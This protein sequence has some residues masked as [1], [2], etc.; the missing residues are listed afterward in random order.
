MADTGFD[1]TRTVFK[2]VGGSYPGRV[3]Q[4]IAAGAP[5]FARDVVMP[6]MLHAKFLRSPYPHA[7][8]ESIDTTAAM[9]IPGVRTIAKW[10]DPDVALLGH[11]WGYG[12]DAPEGMSI[13]DQVADCEET[14]VG[15]CVCTDTEEICDQALKA[16]VINWT[17]LPFYLDPRDSCKPGSAI[18]QPAKRPQDNNFSTANYNNVAYCTPE[19]TNPANQILEYDWNFGFFS[20]HH[21]NPYT[22]VAWFAQDP[23]GASNQPDTLYIEGYYPACV[24]NMMWDMYKPL[25]ID[26]TYDKMHKL[27]LFQGGKYCDYLV[28]RCVFIAPLLAKRTG[29]PVRVANTRRDN[30]DESSGKRWSHVK[31][32]FDS[33]GLIKA[34]EDISNTDGGTRGSCGGSFPDISWSPFYTTWAGKGT[35][36]NCHLHSNSVFSYTNTTRIGLGQDWPYSWDLLTTAI[37]QVAAKVNSDPITLSLLNCHT[38]EMPPAP[39][40]PGSSLHW[41][42]DVGKPLIGWDQK[43]HQPGKGTPDADGKLHGLAFR[44]QMS[45]RHSG[46]KYSCTLDIRGDGKVYMPLRGPVRGQFIE[47]A[48]AWVVAEAL[49]AKREDVILDYDPRAAFTAVGGGSDGGT[50]SPWACKEA[51]GLLRT[52]LVNSVATSWATTADNI[53]IVDSVISKITG[54]PHSQG[55]APFAQASETKD[56]DYTVSYTGAP[57]SATWMTS[58]GRIIDT[59]NA[60]FLEVAVDP[61]TGLVDIVN[62]VTV[63]DVGKVMRLSSVKGQIEQQIVFMTGIGNG[64][65]FIYDRNTGVMLNGNDI[66]YKKPTIKDIPAINVQALESGLGNAA[67]G[68]SGISHSITAK[69]IVPCAVYNALGVWIPDAPVTPQRI[70]KALGKA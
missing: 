17:V 10:N 52:A 15:C 39:G 11:T 6:G 31:V 42:V 33:T 63:A 19:F 4:S 26:L 62:W 35:G 29:K 46:D 23:T 8:V 65:E 67:Y 55:F 1:G 60:S 68:G 21:P 56:R 48:C 28:R 27:S 25:G 5:K 24:D 54:T 66:D 32:A 36:A 37:T 14:E 9:A 57:P 59:M 70:L 13:I 58:S 30:F 40:L 49:G 44:Y 51:A 41:C 47:D 12:S 61:E 34:C 16:L 20:S 50:A 43:W 69:N 22:A 45:P 53:Q 7:R 18:L 64:E 38:P 3:S 2:Y